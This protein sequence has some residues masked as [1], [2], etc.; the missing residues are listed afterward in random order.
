MTSPH[1]DSSQS[2]KYQ[3]LGEDRASVDEKLENYTGTVSWKYL[4]PHFLSGAL[5]FVDPQ[6][7]LAEVGRAFSANHVEQVEHWLKAGDLVKITQLH[8]S[9]WEHGETEFEALVVSPFVLF[10]PIDSLANSSEKSHLA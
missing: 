6:L 8:A 1:S 7:P 2:M 3:I 9:Q 10:R 4:A 5:Y